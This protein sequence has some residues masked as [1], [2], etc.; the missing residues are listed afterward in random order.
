MVEKTLKDRMAIEAERIEKDTFYSAKGHFVAAQKWRSLNTIL[1]L[2]STLLAAVAGTS[3]LVQ[4]DNHS[5]LAGVFAIIVAALTALTTF[6]NPSEKANSHQNAGTRYTAIRNDVRQ[7][8]DLDL[9]REDILEQD[10]LV[11]LEDLKKQRNE[12]NQ[13]SL[14]IPD[15]AYKKVR[16]AYSEKRPSPTRE[17]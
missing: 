10:L 15:S 8:K 2:P 16:R 17:S 3:A 7:F 13:N 4:F 9:H 14:P 1:G 5:I 11:M 12:M 6:L